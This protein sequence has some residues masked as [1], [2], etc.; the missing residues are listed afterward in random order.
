[1]NKKTAIVAIQKQLDDLDNNLV[2]RDIWRFKTGT[3]IKDIFGDNSVEYVFIS[4]FSWSIPYRPFVDREPNTHDF[5]KLENGIKQFLKDCI[6]T[7][8]LKGTYKPKGSNFMSLWG[9]KSLMNMLIFILFIGI[10]IGF[11]GGAEFGYKGL[12]FIF[13]F[14]RTLLKFFS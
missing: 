11:I 7:I 8:N 10:I 2:D 3:L 9:P 13:S 12:S 5:A 4:K 1:M 14:F 6:D